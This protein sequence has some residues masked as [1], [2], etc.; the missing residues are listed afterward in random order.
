MEKLQSR[1][2]ETTPIRSVYIL[3]RIV[4]YTTQD[5]YGIFCLFYFC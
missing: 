4:W 5:K 1:W 2:W 3:G